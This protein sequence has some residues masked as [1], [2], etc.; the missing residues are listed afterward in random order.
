MSSASQSPPVSAVMRSWTLIVPVALMEM[1]RA[2]V[3]L[4]GVLGFQAEA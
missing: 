2:V 1:G 4:S 3:S